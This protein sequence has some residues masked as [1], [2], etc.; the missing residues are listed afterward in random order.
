MIPTLHA[1]DIVEA[2]GQDIAEE[3]WCEYDDDF[4]VSRPS[5]SGYAHWPMV[6]DALGEARARALL[7]QSYCETLR[8]CAL[9]G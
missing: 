5:V 3:Q 8:E 1:I 7:M 9:E 2:I 4:E 6:V